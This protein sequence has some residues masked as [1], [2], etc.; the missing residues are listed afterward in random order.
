MLIKTCAG[1]LNDN[2]PGACIR[3]EA[4]GETGY[5]VG[6]VRELLELFMSPGGVTEAVY[7]FIAK[8]NDMQQTTSGGGVDDEATEVLELLLSQVLQM[9][10]GGEIRDGKAVILLQYLQTLG[11][12]LRNS[13]KSD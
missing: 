6:E 10:T 3:K 4:V 11:L 12:T 8:Y 13:S 5:E 9:I 2:E 1:L 7:F